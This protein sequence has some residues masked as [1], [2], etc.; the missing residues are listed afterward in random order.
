[1]V[2]CGL[3]TPGRVIV[4]G[5]DQIEAYRNLRL[6]ENWSL[7]EL[8]E[9]IGICGA[10]NWAFRLYHS[11]PWYGMACDDEL[12]FTPGFDKILINAAGRW[13]CAHGDD[14][15]RSSYRLWG[16]LTIGGDLLRSAGWWALPGLWHWYFDDVWETIAGEFGLN[17]WCQNVKTEH[18]HTDNGKVQMDAIYALGR[19]RTEQDRQRFDR[20]KSH[21]WPKLKNRLRVAM[22]KKPQIP[23][24][25][26]ARNLLTPLRRMVDYLQQ[27]AQ[28]RPIIVDNNSTWGPLQSWYDEECP[29][30]V[31][32]TGVNG[33]KFGW[34]KHLLDHKPIGV[35][36][37]VVTDSDLILDGIPL[38]VLDVLAAGLDA[39]PNASKVGLSL[40]LD[41][42]PADYRLASQVRQW[43]SQFWQSRCNGFWR[44]GIDTTFAMRR[45]ADPIAFE[46]VGHLR[47]DR[48]YTAEHW[49][50][51][52]TPDLIG[53]SEE[54]QHY[55]D[56]S[57]G[58]GLMW[59][60]AMQRQSDSSF[61]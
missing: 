2:G 56:T 21:E 41:G 22:A 6:P 11:E 54:I 52:W 1:M 8:P 51:H 10:L 53:S 43:E 18:N 35:E 44:A 45:A 34:A 38:D 31:I 49:P 7:I 55:L 13:N 47:S 37:Y 40:D 58:D 25:I 26:N 24:Y 23:V 5:P 50:W 32:H 30:E 59:S 48:P 16:F 20:W 15:W 36:K 28:A 3:S 46:T 57:T 42:I 17:A 29:C 61:A 27:I 9:N 14:G 60:P 12:V 39:N 19:S 4:N 33:G